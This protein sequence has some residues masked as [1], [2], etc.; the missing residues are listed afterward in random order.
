MSP[1]SPDLG[2]SFAGQMRG[3]SRPAG[4]CSLAQ[5]VA[6]GRRCAGLPP[7]EGPGAGGS[8]GPCC[9]WG[10]CRLLS[11]QDAAL[12]FSPRSRASA[13]EAPGHQWGPET[14]RGARGAGLLGTCWGRRLSRQLTPQGPVA[15]PRSGYFCSSWCQRRAGCRLALGTRSPPLPTGT[16]RRKG[17]ERRVGP[18][19]CR[20]T[21]GAQGP[22]RRRRSQRQPREYRGTLGSQQCP[23][24]PGP[25]GHRSC[26]TPRVWGDPWVL[27][28]NSGGGRRR[29]GPGRGTARRPRAWTQQPSGLNGLYAS[30]APPRPPPRPTPPRSASLCLR[31]V[32][33][34]SSPTVQG[35]GSGSATAPGADTW[36]GGCPLRPLEG[37]RRPRLAH[38]TGNHALGGAP[39]SG[40]P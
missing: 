37:E 33:R 24:T 18:L 5:G 27:N 20:R 13:S 30:P 17:G 2:H 1:V 23:L 9:P 39:C 7:P 10:P 6:G 22:S 3:L 19:R 11:R 28:W 35:S 21:P 32:C 26:L 4:G 14:P 15:W 38:R 40:E 25:G 12:P 31:R 34:A 8:L 36:A 29:E 16:Q